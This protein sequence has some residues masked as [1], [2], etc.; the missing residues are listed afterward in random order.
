MLK[1]KIFVQLK[2][3]VLDPQGKAV[4]NSLSQLGYENVIDTRISKYIEISFDSK[5]KS[6][7]TKQVDKICTSL[8]A[9]PNTETYHFELEEL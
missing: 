6:Q 2:P 7:T 1:A 3:S 4:S 5:D 8:L 9:N